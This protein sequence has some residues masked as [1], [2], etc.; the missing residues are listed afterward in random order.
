[1]LL[2][3]GALDILAATPA[4]PPRP[5]PEQINALVL[6]LGSRQFKAREAAG[7]ALE[8]LGAK[9]LPALQSARDNEDPEIRRRAIVLA[10]RIEQRVQSVRILRPKYVQ[11]VCKDMPVPDAVA[12]LA[13][14]SGFAVQLDANARGRLAT[15]KITID[16][17]E[18]TFWQAFDQLCAKAGLVETGGTAQPPQIYNPY[19]RWGGM[20]SPYGQQP[21]VAGPLTVTEGKPEKLPT[22]YVGAVRVRLVSPRNPL[23]GF[24]KDD[25]ETLFGL[26][27]MAEPKLQWRGV[28]GLRILRAVD[29]NGLTLVQPNLFVGEQSVQENLLINVMWFDATGM[30]NNGAGQDAHRVPVRLRLRGKPSHRLAELRGLLSVRVQSP[31]QALITVPNVLKANGTYKGPDT[32]VVKITGVKR[33]SNGT[34]TFEM[35]E[36]QTVATGNGMFGG[37]WGWSSSGGNT[38]GWTIQDA[39]GKKL[40]VNGNNQ[41]TSFNG[42]TITQDTSFSCQLSKSFVEP[43][44]LVYTGTQTLTADVPFTLHDVAL[45]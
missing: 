36:E 40:S 44:K 26:E 19:N 7:L 41:R 24:G 25:G 22:A 8:A 34:L 1:M 21:Q 43:I 20:Y 11:L 17:G 38:T 12:E 27:V 31:P 32:R 9:A 3:V 4:T 16:T 30:Q 6:R 37:G 28:G 42:M 23:V 35:H 39:K 14:K 2:G 18:V 10:D 33:E 45:P 13:K 15:R 5:S 29:D